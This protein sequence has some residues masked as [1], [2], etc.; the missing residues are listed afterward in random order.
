MLEKLKILDTALDKLDDINKNKFFFDKF[1]EINT[2][3]ETILSEIKSNQLN[4]DINKFS[5]EHITIVKNLLNKI[6][7][8][9][10]KI[11]PKAYLLETFSISSR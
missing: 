1:K 3:I 8:L 5:Q 4:D 11:L 10:A 6:D 9:E 2:E 7:K